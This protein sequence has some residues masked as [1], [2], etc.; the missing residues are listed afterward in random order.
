MRTTALAVAV[1]LLATA[2]GQPRA[3]STPRPEAERLRAEVI[4]FEPQGSAPKRFGAISEDPVRLDAFAGWFGGSGSLQQAPEERRAEPGTT[5]VAA[6]DSTGCRVPESVEV[7]RAGTDLRVRFLGGT[8]HPECVRAV[9]PLVHVAVPAEDVRG[10]R[11][12]NGQAPVAAAGPGR[13]ADFVELGT[14]R[15]SPAAAELGDAEAMGRLRARL[16]GG[17]VDLSGATG[18]ALTRTVPAGQR[19][20]AFLLAGCQETS[21][22]LLLSHGKIAADLTG[23]DEVRCIAPAYFL[24]TFTVPD[25]LVP[26]GAVL[27]AGH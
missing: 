4:A 26:K 10:V 22:V 5:Y 13:L 17:G 24:A 11:T 21:A 16:A 1:L 19:G 25:D 6:T 9:G 20:F 3:G 14:V 18:S 12:V 27:G 8:D 7:T 2:C 15:L 23:G